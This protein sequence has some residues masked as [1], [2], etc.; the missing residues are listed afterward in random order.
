MMFI[1]AVLFSLWGLVRLNGSSNSYSPT[2]DRWLGYGWLAVGVG[3]LVLALT[4]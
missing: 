4:S 3:F 1:P 2:F